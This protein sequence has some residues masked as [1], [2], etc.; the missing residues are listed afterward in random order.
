MQS[1][2]DGRRRAAKRAGVDVEH[3]LGGERVGRMAL[4]ALRP[5]LGEGERRGRVPARVEEQ[6]GLRAV[7]IERMLDLQLEILDRRDVRPAGVRH[8]GEQQRP[9]TVVSPCVVAP[10]KDDEPQ[11]SALADARNE[12]AVR[13]DKIDLERH[14]S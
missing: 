1:M 6:R 10:T 13:V 4:A 14:L 7:E 2:N 9:K 3:G 12:R 8:A 5:D 11:V